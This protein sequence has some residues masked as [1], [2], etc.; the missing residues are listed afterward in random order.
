MVEYISMIVAEYL[1][2]NEGVNPNISVIRDIIE[3]LND[4]GTSK[5]FIKMIPTWMRNTTSAMEIFTF[6]EDDSETDS[7]STAEIIWM[8]I[9]TQEVF[10]RNFKTGN[11]SCP[12][13]WMKDFHEGTYADDVFNTIHNACQLKT[14]SR[15]NRMEELRGFEGTASFQVSLS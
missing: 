11:M 12:S 14:E 6:F 5:D 4:E 13:S 15:D 2:T 8:G 1:E 3:L 9:L 10:E 7:D